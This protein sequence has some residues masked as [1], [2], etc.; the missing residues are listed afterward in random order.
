MVAVRVT[1]EAFMA[2]SSSAGSVLSNLRI[3]SK[4]GAGFA[5]VLIIL[6]VSS[7]I[8]WLGFGR[9]ETALETYATLVTNSTVYRNINQ[10]VSQY[11]GHVRKYVY[12]G[13]EDTAQIALKEGAVLRGL[14]A[15]ALSRVTH[16]ERHRLLEAVAKQAGTYAAGFD[17]VHAMN[18][19]QAKLVTEVLDV[20]GQKM[21]DG[22]TS[23]IAG[24]NEVGHADLLPP[25]IEGRRLSLMLRLNV[26]KRLGR[27]GDQAGRHRV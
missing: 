8:A 13:N 11:R 25:T 17:H 22:F 10:T 26:N 14:I 2:N 19:E 5:A 6:A 7:S 21:T 23:I 24:A 20:V 3:G 1:E 4:I 18:S 15:D 12:S 9:V 27:H 16:P